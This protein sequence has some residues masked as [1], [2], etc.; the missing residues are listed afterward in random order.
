MKKKF[1]ALA[2]ALA[3]VFSLAGC[4][5]LPFGDKAPTAE[6]LMDGLQAMDPSKY[7]DLGIEM[8]ISG[9]QDGQA[10]DIG[11]EAGVEMA[12]NIMHIYDMSLD[13]GMSGFSLTVGLEGWLDLD[14]NTQYMSMSALGM[15]SGWT[16]STSDG[17]D[18][19]S[20]DSL[21]DAMGAS[22][23][24]NA[25]EYV[26]EPHEKGQDWAVS[27]TADGGDLASLADGF[28]SDYGVDGVD[29][30]A[31]SAKAWFDE[32]SH[33][34]KSITVTADSSADGTD[35]SVDI[36]IEFRTMNGDGSLSIPADVIESAVEESDS[37]NLF[38]GVG[39][40]VIDPFGSGDDAD[41]GFGGFDGDDAFSR[42]SDLEYDGLSSGKL[43]NDGDGT[44]EL[45]DSLAARI[46]ELD[47]D[48]NNVYVYHYSGCTTVSYYTS[49]DDWS[50]SLMI[51]RVFD[52]SW[53]SAEDEFIDQAEFL[54]GWNEGSD[55]YS[56]DEH[57]ILFLTEGS[58]GCWD[59]DYATW[60]GDIYM[61]ADVYTYGDSSA[62]DV[63]QYLLTMMG[64]AAVYG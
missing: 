38:G 43:V 4:S 37:G 16:K 59:L 14:G 29:D 34:I 1:L 44:D 32:E 36:R 33:A 9:S 62:E 41:P 55:P 7:N 61:S 47:P 23:G 42:P 6:D 46:V 19:F 31:V 39:G 3:M 12:G 52:P 20:M 45:M 27:W 53:G 28:A 56:E 8:A 35:A 15:D 51:E 54:R 5:G 49:G 22:D 64:N 30:V 2:M 26:L 11:L 17:S 18:S 57:N 24:N 50:G 10:V 25:V 63:M 48:C 13:M 40:D 58:L 21:M 60:E